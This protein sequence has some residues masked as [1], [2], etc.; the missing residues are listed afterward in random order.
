MSRFT[1]EE[2]KVILAKARVLGCTKYWT[3]DKGMYLLDDNNLLAAYAR[4]GMKLW[5]S[6]HRNHKIDNDVRELKNL[7]KRYGAQVDTGS[8]S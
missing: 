7:R 5:V 8:D 2:M 6:P 1:E 4:P 3:S